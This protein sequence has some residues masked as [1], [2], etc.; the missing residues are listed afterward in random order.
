MKS[1]KINSKI[2]G[3]FNEG[4]TG[5]KTTKTLVL[6]DKNNREFERLASS[7]R[8]RSIRGRS[9]QRCFTDRINHQ[10]YRYRL[11]TI[12]FG[13]NEYLAGAIQ[14]GMLQL[15]VNFPFHF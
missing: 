9:F 15:F 2:T 6:E 12:Y 13:G 11:K 5:A 4:I 7:M 3:S 14:I 10:L 1:E 8:T